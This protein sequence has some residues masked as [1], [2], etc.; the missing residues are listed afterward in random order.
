[1]QIIVNAEDKPEHIRLAASFLLHLVGDLDD[2]PE[3]PLA[4]PAP[5]EA[6]TA[7]T[8]P[9]PPPPPPPPERVPDFQAPASSAPTAANA[10][11]A[12]SAPAP[13]ATTGNAESGSSA[14]EFDSAGLPWDGRIHQARKGVKKDGTWKIIKGCDPTLVESVTKELVARRASPTIA[15]AQTDAFPPAAATGSAPPPPPPA[16]PVPLPPA[17]TGATA[18]PLPPQDAAQH[19]PVGAGTAQVPVPVPPAPPVGAVSV[20]TGYRELI[21][22]ISAGTKAGKLD[23]T[24]ISQI[25]QGHGCPSLQALREMP[26]LIPLVETDVD[27]AVLS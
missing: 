15:P 2:A 21:A 18:M 26:H 10:S 4:P 3:A 6:P 22:K 19:L 23:P 17:S 20:S 27:V 16:P 5:L 25:V 8:P 14:P 9:P 11:P 1:M 13:T 24:K 7:P 12:A